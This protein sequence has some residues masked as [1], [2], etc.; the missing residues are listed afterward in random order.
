MTLPLFAIFAHAHDSEPVVGA[1]LMLLLPVL[2]IL[3]L[4]TIAVV[5]VASRRGLLG[6]SRRPIDV[7]A[8]LA[9]LSVALSVGAGGIHFAVIQ[10]HLSEDIAAAVFFLALAWVQVIWAMAYLVRPNDG[11]RVIAIV[12]NAATVGVWIVSRTTGLPIG[13]E[14]WTPEAVGLAD[15]LSTSF[16]V[17]LVALLTA[18]LLPRLAAHFSGYS[19]PLEKAYVFA[20]FSVVVV[21]SLT[22]L[23]LLGTPAG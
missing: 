12:V 13:P 4:A 20:T 11:L 9:M 23:A 19:V 21:A 16:E 1:G 17:V 15:L 7:S 8:P 2:P 10:E 3:L 14:P 6:P 5:S 22:G 18:S